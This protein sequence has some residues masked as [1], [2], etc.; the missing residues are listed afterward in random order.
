MLTLFLFSVPFFIYLPS[1]YYLFSCLLFS[2][3]LFYLFSVDMSSLSV[4]ASDGLFFFIDE[5]SLFM[6]VLLFLVIYVSFFSAPHETVDKTL[7]FSFLFL[8]LSCY[9][10][11]STSNYFILY[12]FYEA[13]IIPIVYIILKWGSYPERSL[14]S[15]MIIIYTLLFSAPM[16]ILLFYLNSTHCT[17]NMFSYYYSHSFSSSFMF[18]LIVFL[19]FSVKLP[20]FGLHY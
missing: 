12:F 19:C 15:I 3:I 17:F 9:I 14:S 11:F 10:V 7:V 18:S 20:I 13:S 16:L 1:N 6:V 2:M 8:F 5:S 4:L